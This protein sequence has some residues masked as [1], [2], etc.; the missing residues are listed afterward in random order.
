MRTS[1]WISRKVLAVLNTAL[2]AASKDVERELEGTQH[3]TWRYTTLLEKGSAPDT[4][5]KLKRDLLMQALYNL[6]QHETFLKI[7]LVSYRVVQGGNGF[8][9]ENNTIL[10]TIV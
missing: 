7:I 6:R 5:P 3:L 1:L 10:Y 2:P 9:L 4:D 8:C